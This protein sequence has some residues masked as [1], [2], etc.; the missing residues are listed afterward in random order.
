MP[1]QDSQTS[2]VRQAQILGAV[3]G[4][5]SYPYIEATWSQSLPDWIGSHVRAFEFF[6]GVPEVLVPDNLHDFEGYTPFQECRRE[7]LVK[8]RPIE[9]PLLKAD[10]GNSSINSTVFC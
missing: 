10:G 8:N 6:G 1:I 3:L 4:A 9:K 5:S 2:E 7:I